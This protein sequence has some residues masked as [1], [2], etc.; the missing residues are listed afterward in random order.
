[1][2][3]LTGALL[4][5]VALMAALARF[6]DAAP[7]WLRY[8]AISPDGKQIAFAYRGD[9]YLV[10][11]EGGVAVPLTQHAAHDV[12]PIWSPDGKRIVF[13][14]DRYGNFDLFALS[15][16]G[17]RTRRLTWHSA[18]D[19]PGDFTADGQS[20]YFSS[21]R[22]DAAQASGFPSWVLPELYRVPV[23][24]GPPRQVLSTP[25]EAVSVAP[26]GRSLLYQ[27]RKG[28]EN[29]WRKHH[30]SSVTRD[31][32]HYTPGTETHAQLTSFEGEDRNPVWGDNGDV[33]FLS[34]RS[35]TFNVW[36][37]SLSA[38]NVAETAEQLTH[39]GAHPVRFLSRA[40]TGQLCFSWHGEIYTMMP[41][42]EPSKVPIQVITQDRVA[43]RAI[44]NMTAGVT[45]IALSPNGAELALIVRGDIFVTSVKHK[46]TRQITA[47]PEQERSVSFSPDG[48]SLLYASERGGSWNLY[49]STLAREDEKRFFLASQ[50]DEETV[51]ATPV[52]AFQPVYSPDGK[53]VAYLE[54]RN[55]LRVINLESRQSRTLLDGQHTY[56]YRDGDQD[57]A[58]SPDGAWLAVKYYDQNRWSGE[59]GLVPAGGH[60]QVR[61]LTHSGYGDWDP[62]W[63]RQGDAIFWIS[64][65]HGKRSHGSWGSDRDVYALFLTQSAYD[66]FRLTQEEHEVLSEAGEKAKTSESS[67]QEK[68]VP[69]AID[70]D[71]LADRRVRLTVHS[72]DLKEALCRLRAISSIISAGLRRGT[73]SGCKNSKRVKPNCSPSLKVGA[74]SSCW[75]RR[76]SPCT[77]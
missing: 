36:R 49:R 37:F 51:L 23:E 45:D 67:D 7:L 3:Q 34:E 32:W 62:K 74:Y 63:T 55:T 73:I 40:A 65:R 77:S 39:F 35:G 38:T 24:G 30:T 56:S 53:D 64:N 57:F 16:D 4:A 13:R 1:M 11:A 31:L 76:V 70:F 10:D 75:M 72:S 15:L 43:A 8:P 25:A 22:L 18:H 19:Y 28:Y 54:E 20:V 33:F 48:R 69:I 71:G 47:T 27:D 6:A 41:G 2:K 52:E 46:A 58:W 26:D 14:A 50:I 17:G 9:L 29:I 12:E 68:P 42:E 21:Q 66:Q 61:N 44:R 60:G 5:V 59:V